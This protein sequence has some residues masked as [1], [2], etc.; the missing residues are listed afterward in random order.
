[1]L[2]ELP[3]GLRLYVERLKEFAGLLGIVVVN[4]VGHAKPLDVRPFEAGQMDPALDQRRE[5]GRVA[6]RARDQDPRVRKQS[7]LQQIGRVAERRSAAHAFVVT[8]QNEEHPVLHQVQRT[9]DLGD[10]V[11][12]RGR[13]REQFPREIIQDRTAAKFAQRHDKGQ[14]WTVAL[15]RPLM[16]QSQTEGGPPAPG[17]TLDGD[18]SRRLGYGAVA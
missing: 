7:T 3:D 1:M 5:G 11:A 12:Q 13:S 8:V 15:G 4:K 9:P 10:R 2:A 17:T 16:Q 18:A 6:G 14:S